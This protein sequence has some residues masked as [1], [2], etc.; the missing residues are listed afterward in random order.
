MSDQTKFVKKEMAIM[1]VK[2]TVIQIRVNQIRKEV[3]DAFAESEGRT[4]SNYL[5]IAGLE[6]GIKNKKTMDFLG[7]KLKERLK[8]ILKI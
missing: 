5:E 1:G 8:E 2:D 3:L 4:L 6:R 7:K